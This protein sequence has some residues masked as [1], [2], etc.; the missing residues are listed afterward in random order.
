MELTT[1]PVQVTASRDAGTGL[2]YTFHLSPESPIESLD[3]VVTALPQGGEIS[4]PDVGGGDC[5][6]EARRTPSGFEIKRGCHGA[7][8]SWQAATHAETVVWLSRGAT[9]AEAQRSGCSLWVPRQ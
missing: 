8:G 1:L 2:S 3:A 5:F 7:A 4:V 6:L 9:S